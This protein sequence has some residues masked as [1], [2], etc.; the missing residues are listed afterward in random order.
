MFNRKIP[1]NT[2]SPRRCSAT[3]LF[4][5][6]CRSAVAQLLLRRSLFHSDKRTECGTQEREDCPMIT[7][8]LPLITNRRRRNYRNKGKARANN[9]RITSRLTLV[10]YGQAISDRPTKN[11]Q[12]T[13]GLFTI[14]QQRPKALQKSYLSH[15]GG[16]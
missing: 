3:A 13:L 5:V 12:G 16:R 1:V 15:Q 8:T 2:T 14:A 10:C 6:S 9:W 4:R 11:H 7:G